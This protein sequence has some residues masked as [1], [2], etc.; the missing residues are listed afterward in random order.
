MSV[1][2]VRRGDSDCTCSPSVRRRYLARLSGPL[3]D[4]ID[5]QFRVHRITTTQLRLADESPSLTTA[6]ARGRVAL[7]RASAAERLAHT[8]WI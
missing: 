3:L 7:A 4:R 1:R 8:P 5:I 6:A 2:P